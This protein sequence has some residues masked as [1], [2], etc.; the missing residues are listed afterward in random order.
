MIADAEYCIVEN[1]EPS[2]C[3]ANKEVYDSLGDLYDPILA[4]IVARVN[5]SSDIRCAHIYVT[6]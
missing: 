3:L 1:S 6:A 4:N 5:D 2:L